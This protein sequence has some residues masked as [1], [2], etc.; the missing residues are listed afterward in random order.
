MKRPLV[1]PA[2]IVAMVAAAGCSASVDGA[3]IHF[4]ADVDKQPQS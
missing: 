4:N 3:T 2:L 1:L